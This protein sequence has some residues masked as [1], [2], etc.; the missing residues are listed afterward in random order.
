MQAAEKGLH[1]IAWTGS[2]WMQ[3]F[4]GLVPGAIG[5][6]STLACLMVAVVLFGTRIASARIIVGMLIGM[7]ASAWLFN[8]LG[9]PANA[10]AALSWHWHLVLGSFAFGTIFLATDPVSAPRIASSRADISG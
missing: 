2:T 1:T 6:T 7:T 10:Y 4:L 8:L 3:S 5:A 9:D